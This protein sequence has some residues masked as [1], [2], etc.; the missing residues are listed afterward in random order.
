MSCFHM[1]DVM[2]WCIMHHDATMHQA[3]SGRTNNLAMHEQTREIIRK[4]M[5]A[6]AVPS[7]RRL[8]IDCQMNQST[9]QRFMAN[10]TDS[11]NFNNLQSIAQHFGVT[12]SQ[13]IGETPL[14]E[15]VKIRQV[16]MAM[17]TMPEYMKDVVVATS[18]TLAN[19]EK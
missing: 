3:S 18:Q 11:L 5:T 2:R 12:V 1:A 10:E 14:Q 4:L 7:E 15:D 9:L 13:L 19:K 8:A 17:Q 6:N 16:V